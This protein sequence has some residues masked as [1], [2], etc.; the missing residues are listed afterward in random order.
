MAP[1]KQLPTIKAC[2]FDMDGLLI[3]SEDK[4]TICTNEV[5]N[6]YGRPNLPWHIKAQ[7]Q[8]RPGPTAS[9]ILFDWAQLPITPEEYLVKISSRQQQH[10]RTCAPLPG[11][12]NLLQTL[13]HRSSSS[14]SSS[15]P[16]TSTS[17]STSPR[18][19]EL[20]LAT[21][22]HS[23]NF[24]L[25]T[26]H[27][28][29]NVF[30]VFNPLHR[31]LGDDSRIGKGRGKPLPDIWLVALKTINDRLEQ[32]KPEGYEKIKPE[33]CLVFED[34]VPGTESA[35][36]AG[37]Q[38]VWCPHPGLLKEFEGR[39]ERV[40]AGLMGQYREEEKEEEQ[41]QE[42]GGKKD[43]SGI[44]RQSGQTGEIG[45]GWGRLLLS[46]EDFPYAEYGIEVKEESQL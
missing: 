32:E 3:D 35:R 44:V 11:V 28:E 13:K 5:L 36:R 7:L 34:S 8:G 22:S 24:H 10:F 46:L 31:V 42:L 29:S 12:I 18:R 14:S 30:S 39:E 9:K 43:E 17:T 25:K 2:L 4:Y 40:L 6:E 23:T 15:S 41:E 45:D 21:S 37:M 27:L 38:V 26:A 1:Q 16:S 19:I 20:A 33:E